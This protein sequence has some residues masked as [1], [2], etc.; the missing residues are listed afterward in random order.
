MR[1]LIWGDRS[2]SE[3]QGGGLLGEPLQ[4]EVAHGHRWVLPV[5]GLEQAPRCLHLPRV[6]GLVIG[7]GPER[8]HAAG[9]V[10]LF[11]ADLSRG[12]V[13]PR[14]ITCTGWNT[15]ALASGLAKGALA[16]VRLGQIGQGG[17]PAG[18]A[19]PNAAGVVRVVL[20]EGVIT[21]V[22]ATHVVAVVVPILIAGVMAG[23]VWTGAS[24]TVKGHPHSEVHASVEEWL[25]CPGLHTV[26]LNP[27]LLEPPRDV[28][29]DLVVEVPQCSGRVCEVLVLRSVV[30]VVLHPVHV[31][32]VEGRCAGLRKHRVVQLV[33]RQ[34]RAGGRS[35]ERRRICTAR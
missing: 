27:R 10:Q 34:R 17:T 29:H 32:R 20:R 31:K 4:I 25:R 9:I 21:E 15:R 12:L 28:P 35:C 3:L 19:V 30:L 24:P 7:I 26:S 13:V 1:D 23:P 2:R 5:L 14:A 16:V 22:V 6:G 33:V 8:F 18:Q 11:Q